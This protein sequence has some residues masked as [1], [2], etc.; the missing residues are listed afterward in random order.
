MEGTN[1]QRQGRIHAATDSHIARAAA[2]LRAG[3]LVALPTETVYG[4]AADASN[5]A[6][7]E[8]IYRVKGRPDFNPLIVH[9]LN[10]E[11]AAELANIDAR[12]H[13]LADV[14]W[15]GPL[16]MV[17][18]LKAASGVAPS[19]TAGLSTIA[20]RSPAHPV[21]RQLLLE[22]GI[23]LAAPSAN[24]SGHISP[25]TAAHVEASLGD[26]APF[27]LD[28]GMSERGLESTIIA[29]R[30]TGWQLLREG[31]LTCD[32]I[33]G[34]L[35]D[36]PMPLTDQRIEA[37]GQ[38]ARHYAPRKPLRLDVVD[39]RDGEWLIGFGDVTGDDNL[40]PS[41]DLIEAAA[42]LFDALHRAEASDA[43]TIA[44]APIP[45]DGIGA[46]IHD[47]LTRAAAE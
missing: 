8:G 31:P 3:G 20:I 17:L 41:R 35:G 11:Q 37:P 10:I 39:R 32:M 27:I 25:T 40:S 1:T 4:L 16:T 12:A 9:V 2:I 22:S 15:P 36:A 42:R 7:V 19:V 46:A 26:D 6:A 23:N 28:G 33:T 24:K 44:V 21:M 38:L 43:A 34:I 18:P 47:R 14:F 13:R 29:L 5:Q 45:S 30:P